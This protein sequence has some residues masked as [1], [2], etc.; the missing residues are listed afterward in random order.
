MPPLP[1]HSIPGIG[2]VG[3][4]FIMSNCHLP[5]YRKACIQPVAITSRNTASAAEVAARHDIQRVHNNL[6]ELLDDPEVHVLDIA[7]P[8]DVQP[9]VIKKA[10]EYKGKITGILA[11]KPLAPSY[12]EAR[13][14]VDL[15]EKANIRLVVNQNMRYDQSVYACQNLLK[16]N[17][18][19]EP[20]LATIEMRAIP[21][22]MPWQ[23]RLGWV[24]LR[25]MSIHHLDT[26]RFWFGNPVRVFTSSRSDPRTAQQFD[27][28]DGICLTILEYETSTDT[29]MSSS[30]GLRCLSLDDVW[31]GPDR[32]GAE[33]ES[34]VNFRIEGMQGIAKGS[35]GWPA[36]PRHQPSTLAWTD[37]TGNWHHPQ[38]DE[39]WFPDAFV[40]PMAELLR[41]LE[42]TEQALCTGRDNLITLAAVEAAY[43]SAKEHRSVLL[44]EI[45]S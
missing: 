22:W 44:S 10:A 37:T 11:Q 13:K 17:I 19:G 1:Q 24:T 8:P 32:K 2:C 7:V 18:L 36:W 45:L 9:A 25:I 41:D 15:C 40:G 34:F 26:F 43:I 39:A 21:H 31:S 14:L 33:E 12:A 6:I 28:S 3:A 29:G 35:L 23:K 38:W 20:I 4:G 30:C 5:A 16:K 27:H 42:G